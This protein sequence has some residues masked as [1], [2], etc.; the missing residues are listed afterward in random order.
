MVFLSA[1]FNKKADSWIKGRKNQLQNISPKLK[2]WKNQKIGWIHAASYGE[3]E[4]SRPL[5]RT[6]QSHF[7]DLKFVISFYSPSG[8]ENIHFEDERFLKIYLEKD[9]ANLHEKYIE[10]IDPDFVV[11]IKY[12]FWFNFLRILKARKIPFYFTSLHMNRDHYLFN[13]FF[14]A[15]L[16]LIKSSHQIFCHNKASYEILKE[17]GFNNISILGDTRIKQVQLNKQNATII[18]W[19]KPGQ[20]TII[21]G[22]CTLFESVMICNYINSNPGYNFIIAPHDIDE[23]SISAFKDKIKR[24]TSL[25]SESIHTFKHEVLIIDTLGDLKHLYGNADVAYVGAG[26]EKGP[27]N[28]LEPLVYGIPVITGPNIRKFPMAQLLKSKELLFV[29]E[30]KNQLDQWIQHLLEVDSENFSDLC[31]V[32]FEENQANLDIFTQEIKQVIGE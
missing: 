30:K 1:F 7:P 8:Y 12:E 18:Q 23:H 14:K 21:F 5:I 26:F 15:F 19:S 6:L 4:M 24:G 16:N 31:T 9:I 22:S 11:F 25:Y 17:K 10:V 20:Q 3:F 29:I 2:D 13:P 27:H 28:V 32:F